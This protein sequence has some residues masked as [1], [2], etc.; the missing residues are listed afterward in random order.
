MV[1]SLKLR[2]IISVLVRFSV[3]TNWLLGG[4]VCIKQ[5]V[6]KD[7]AFSAYYFN[8]LL[9]LDEKKKNEKKPLDAFILE[10]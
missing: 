2:G 10:I 9:T 4:F 3:K 8:T 5:S 7:N 6:N 1:V